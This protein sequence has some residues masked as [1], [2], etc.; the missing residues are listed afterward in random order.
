MLFSLFTL[1]LSVPSI[2]LVTLAIE[3]T[4][5][6]GLKI[7]SR[8]TSDKGDSRIEVRKYYLVEDINCLSMKDEWKGLKSIGMPVY[9]LF[10]NSLF[11]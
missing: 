8:T 1:S 7:K 6:D 9:L 3:K 10:N 5:F 2:Y 11:F 4:N